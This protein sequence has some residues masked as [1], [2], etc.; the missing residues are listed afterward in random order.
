M[1]PHHHPSTAACHTAS[2]QPDSLARPA[3]PIGPIHGRRGGARRCLLRRREGWTDA[4]YT[5][6][7]AIWPPA[8][9]ASR[10]LPVGISGAGSPAGRDAVNGTLIE[11]QQLTVGAFWPAT[12]TWRDHVG[13]LCG[14]DSLVDAALDRV[15]KWPH[16][17]ALGRDAITRQRERSPGA[18][19][20]RESALEFWRMV[21]W[22]TSG[23][24]G[25][26][27][28]M[29]AWAHDPAVPGIA[30]EPGG[31][32]RDC[33][34]TASRV[35]FSTE[36]PIGTR[37]FRHDGRRSGLPTGATYPSQ[38]HTAGRWGYGNDLGVFSK[39]PIDERTLSTHS[40]SGFRRT[41]CPRVVASAAILRRA[42]RST[43]NR[44]AGRGGTRRIV[45]SPDSC[46]RRVLNGAAQ[47]HARKRGSGGRQ[48]LRAMSIPRHCGLKGREGEMPPSVRV[49]PRPDHDVIVA[50]LTRQACHALGR[51]DTTSGNGA[52]TCLSEPV[53]PRWSPRGRRWPSPEERRGDRAHFGRSSATAGLVES[54]DGRGF[55]PTA[56]HPGHFG[57]ESMRSRAAE[58]GGRLTI[59]SS[60]GLGTTVRVRVP[61]EVDGT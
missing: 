2:A 35:V 59:R 34:H 8:G 21:A 46:L 16:V 54:C 7:G 27:P 57:L 36:E 26:L 10:P 4:A 47:S 15:E 14:G 12:G 38:S 1:L 19:V 61:A 48:P 41:S 23:K 20:C 60:P 25:V 30:A 29:I 52:A 13:A 6:S 17:I 58:I 31:R 44:R 33:G 50:A 11:R 9:M 45:R 49:T 37:G 42:R 24:I 5:A 3:S 40:T 43:P 32:R 28:L 55:D 56:G 18:E 39:Q 53:K 51:A 22:R